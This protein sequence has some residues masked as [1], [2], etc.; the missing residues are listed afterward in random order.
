[1]DNYEQ[2]KEGNIA[3]MNA[4]NCAAQ[5]ISAMG[6]TT[7]ALDRI[8]IDFKDLT[9]FIYGIQNG[10]GVSKQPVEP[11]NTPE[12]QY[13]PEQH[14]PTIQSNT[15]GQQE[16]CKNCGAKRVLNP[17]TGKMFC[18]NKCWLKE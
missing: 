1:M 3:L 5:I 2:I 9:L 4:K 12:P 7:A 16:F 6:Y 8:K 18:S 17:K 14:Q 13:I 11:Q 10:V 15:K